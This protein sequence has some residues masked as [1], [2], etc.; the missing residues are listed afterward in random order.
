MDFPV[1]IELYRNSEFAGAEEV[2]N[3]PSFAHQLDSFA[4]AV[5]GGAP[6]PIS[7]ED[8]WQNQMVLDAAY[9]SLKT[10]IAEPVAM[11]RG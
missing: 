10:G 4:D 11:V 7:G 3:R 5:N 6:F 1:R 2:H 8:G 9:L